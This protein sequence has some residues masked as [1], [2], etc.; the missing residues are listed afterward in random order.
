MNQEA[1]RMMLLRVLDGAK[2]KE[3][4][5]ERLAK[6]TTALMPLE[7]KMLWNFQLAIAH[8][9]LATDVSLYDWMETQSQPVSVRWF[10]G[11]IAVAIP[12]VWFDRYLIDT[13]RDEIANDLMEQYGLTYYEDEQT[14]TSLDDYNRY[15]HYKGENIFIYKNISSEDNVH[16]NVQFGENCNFYLFLKTNDKELTKRLREKVGGY[17]YEALP[18]HLYLNVTE[19]G[20]DIPDDK[21]ITKELSEEKMKRLIE[22]WLPKCEN[23]AKELT[24]YPPEEL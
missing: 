5:K 1:V 2:T 18:Y 13:K 9:Y 20:K 6:E 7:G 19:D 21:Y 11:H 16:F 10:K 17:I 24:I 12:R 15:G 23:A 3:E 8:N 22:E 4:V 14:H